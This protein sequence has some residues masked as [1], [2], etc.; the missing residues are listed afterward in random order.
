[1]LKKK[2]EKENKTEINTE[3]STELYLTGTVTDKLTG[4][5]LVGVE[6]KLKDTD[7]KVYTDFDGMFAF[8]EIKPGTYDI[9]AQYVSYEKN[10][11]RNQNINI[12]NTSIK[13]ELSPV[14]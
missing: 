14:N 2:Y 12:L 10:E 1:M 3:K 9:S 5:A 13:L 7:K 8:E 4:E 6:I 11:L